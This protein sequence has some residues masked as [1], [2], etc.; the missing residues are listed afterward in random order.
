VTKE[1][2]KEKTARIHCPLRGIVLSAILANSDVIAEELYVK[3]EAEKEAG[4][5]I[6]GEKQP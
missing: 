5:S 6:Y 1:Y 2:S 4:E 3:K